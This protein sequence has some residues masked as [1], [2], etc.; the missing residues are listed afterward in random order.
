MFCPKCG[1]E[2]PDG[3][4]FCPECGFPIENV[5]EAPKDEQK[6]E[7]KSE[8]GEENKDVPIITERRRGFS[9]LSIIGFIISFFGI[10]GFIGAIIC[11]I[12]LIVN[13]KNRRALSIAAIIIGLLM[14]AIFAVVIFGIYAYYIQ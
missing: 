9:S 1:K 3:S 4:K 12:E 6:E 14:T 7:A 13:K 5:K 8:E 2:I 10:F 11:A